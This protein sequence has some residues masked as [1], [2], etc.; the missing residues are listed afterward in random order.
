MDG[1]LIVL[2]VA[3][4][5]VAGIVAENLGQRWGPATLVLVAYFAC[6]GAIGV[7]LV[8]RGV[9]VVEPHGE[10][11]EAGLDRDDD[12]ENDEDDEDDL[13][14]NDGRVPAGSVAGQG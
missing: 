11:A 12:D 5:V 4:S 14:G 1:F 13:L 9:I 7:A 10:T 3:A 8:R 2:V 6:V